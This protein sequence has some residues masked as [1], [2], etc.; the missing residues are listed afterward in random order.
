MGGPAQPIRC[1]V[2]PEE[3][4]MPSCLVGNNA[5]QM[6]RSLRPMLE[7]YY[8][9]YRKRDHLHN[10]MAPAGVD[11]MELVECESNLNDLECDYHQACTGWAWYDEDE[12]E[13]SSCCEEEE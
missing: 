10:T 9:M 11:E 6:R 5:S 3:V 1:A 7:T 12:D 4:A 8:N 2:G 13:D